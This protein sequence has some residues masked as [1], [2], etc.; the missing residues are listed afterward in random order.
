MSNSFEKLVLEFVERE[1]IN[2]AP[3]IQDF[4]LEELDELR[5]KIMRFID[6]KNGSK[7]EQ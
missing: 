6:K 2:H 5:K 1:L 4:I 7:G 3:E